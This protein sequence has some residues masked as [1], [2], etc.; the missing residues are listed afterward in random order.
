[1]S[2]SNFAGDRGGE[3]GEGEALLAK[4]GLL[5]ERGYSSDTGGTVLVQPGSCEMN[6]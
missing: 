2:L 5:L 6:Q 3:R 4:Q 1:M